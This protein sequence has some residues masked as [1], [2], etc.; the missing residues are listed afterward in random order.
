[1]MTVVVENRIR[2]SLLG[3]AG[4]IFLGTLVELVLEEHTKET[5]QLVP[6][7]LCALGIITILAVFWRPSR[8][9][10]RS[11]RVTMVLNTAG[12]LLG[13]VLHLYNNFAFEREIRP[14]AEIGDLLIKTLKGANP[15]IAPGI[16][17]FV[18]VMVI[19]A[20]YHHPVLR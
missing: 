12:G 18:A 14:N 7:F 3:L 8:M 5:L 9:T 15:L 17:I 6:F 4:F 11:L 1:M 16:L 13:I 19:I 2:Q 10:L 20:T